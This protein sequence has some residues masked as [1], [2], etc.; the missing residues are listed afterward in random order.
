M[1]VSDAHVFP[2]F[3]TPVLTQLSFQSHQLLCSHASAEVRGENT[4]ERK[5]ASTGS[6][7]H[8]HQV[9]SLTRSPL[10]HPGRVKI[11]LLGKHTEKTVL[12]SLAQINLQSKINSFPNKPWFL[13]VCSKSLT[14]TLKG[15]GEIAHNEQFL[16]FPQCVLLIQKT[17]CSF[18]QI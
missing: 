13:R 10:N 11:L 15:K 9:M 3:L 6:R 1:A 12:V 2:G 5:L 14:K 16:L 8:N 18:H 4:L 17:F 7:T